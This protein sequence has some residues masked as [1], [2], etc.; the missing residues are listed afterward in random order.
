MR[1]IIYWTILIIG[2]PIALMCILS[3]LL[4]QL[5]LVE[6]DPKPWNW[7]T[8]Y[9]MD[10]FY[11]IALITQLI[12][13]IYKTSWDYILTIAVAGYSIFTFFQS[14]LETML[15]ITGIFD[16]PISNAPFVLSFMMLGMMMGLL[17]MF[18]AVTYKDHWIRI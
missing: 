3:L 15:D 11:G 12:G 17:M 8:V 10:I 16:A 1:R 14:A 5:G 6:P 7:P 9:V 4:I 18:Y 13:F 2:F